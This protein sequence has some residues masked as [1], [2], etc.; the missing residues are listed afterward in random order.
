MFLFSAVLYK[1][2]L[3]YNPR[4]WFLSS[5]VLYCIYKV[6]LLYYP[7][8]W[9]LSSVMLYKAILLYY[10]RCWSL[11]SAVL[12]KVMLLYYPRCW[13]SSSAWCWKP[14]RNHWSERLLGSSYQLQARRAMI[15]V[16]KESKDNCEDLCILSILLK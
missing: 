13:F 12:S 15:T 1:V 7:R 2:I 4:C 6:I 8:C 9:F 11:S 16:K 14:R 10:P 5:A 3:L